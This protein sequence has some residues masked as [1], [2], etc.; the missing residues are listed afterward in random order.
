MLTA[1]HQPK[2]W[3]RIW[4]AE[5]D[6]EL[7]ARLREIPL[8]RQGM[9]GRARQQRA[10]GRRQLGADITDLSSLI[11]SAP[12]MINRVVGIVSKAQ[13]YLDVAES[14]VDD[15]ALP[16][17]MSRIRTIRSLNNPGTPATPPAPAADG[18]LPP[19]VPVGLTK[20]M[21]AVDGYIWARQHPWIVPL[22]GVGVIGVLGGAGFLLGRWYAKR[23]KATVS[24]RSRRK[25]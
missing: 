19:V 14:I 12:G 1:I 18:S 23:S 3:P 9:L 11:S 21:P 22:V 24:G 25:R 15:P 13:P 16:D 2:T 7:Q 4:A 5:A 20:F 6:D 17:F 10:A 8:V